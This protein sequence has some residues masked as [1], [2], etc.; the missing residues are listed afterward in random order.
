V[1]PAILRVAQCPSFGTVFVKFVWVARVGTAF[2][3]A[4]FTLPVLREKGVKEM[5]KMLSKKKVVKLLATALGEGRLPLRICLKCGNTRNFRGY[6]VRPDSVMIKI[7]DK[8]VYDPAMMEETEETY[9]TQE[10]AER[11]LR[12]GDFSQY[13]K[14]E[15][16]EFVDEHYCAVDPELVGVFCA[17]CGSPNILD[18]ER[19]MKHL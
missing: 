9:V 10:Q 3:H 15:L 7:H 1:Q 12:A 2:L 19:I 14:A 5:T 8:A 4:L 16:K 6:E 17:R 11:L 18:R 13:S